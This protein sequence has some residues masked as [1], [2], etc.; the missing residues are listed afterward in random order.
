MNNRKEFAMGLLLS[1]H[2]TE[3]ENL[4]HSSGTGKG[5]EWTP[6]AHKITVLI[7]LYTTTT[8]SRSLPCDLEKLQCVDWI[9]IA[10]RA[11]DASI[12]FAKDLQ[13]RLRRFYLQVIQKSPLSS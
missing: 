10:P 7:T 4:A 13:A 5:M 2:I 6:V 12:S 1:K 8:A 3:C 11:F 9:I